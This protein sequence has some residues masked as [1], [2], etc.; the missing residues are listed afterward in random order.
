MNGVKNGQKWPKNGQ[1]CH[2]PGVP[3]EKD[4]FDKKARQFSI[5]FS[6]F[7]VKKWGFWP[8]MVPVIKRGTSIA[9]RLVDICFILVCYCA[10]QWSQVLRPQF[11]SFHAA[12]FGKM[13]SKNGL[14]WGPWDPY[15]ILYKVVDRRKVV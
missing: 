13:G 2:F 5:G 7:F 14:S 12:I 11:R 6:G 10:M 4:D 8:K 3:R 15:I 9:L 1:K